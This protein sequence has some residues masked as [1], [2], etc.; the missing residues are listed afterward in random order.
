MKKLLLTT[1]T[2]L[3]A[4]LAANAVGDKWTV[5]WDDP[6]NVNVIA[7]D[8]GENVT[9][10]VSS[11]FNSSNGIFNTKN[12]G[13]W[14]AKAGINSISNDWV[15]IDLGASQ[16]LKVVEIH[17]EA[18]KATQFELYLSDSMPSYEEKG[19]YNEIT[20]AWLQSHKPDAKH[21]A[22]ADGEYITTTLL[23]ATGRYLLLYCTEYNGF[24]R[25]YGINIYQIQ[26]GDVEVENDIQSIQILPVNTYR[27]VENEVI[28]YGINQFNQP[29]E[30]FDEAENISLTCSDPSVDI[31]PE[32]SLGHFKV[33]A[34]NYGRFELLATATFTESNELTSSST[35]YS[36]INWD[37]N[38]NVAKGCT[39]FG[40]INE[41]LDQFPNNHP[42]SNAV[43]GDD[44]SYYVYNGNYGGSDSWVFIDLGNDYV[45]EA[46]EILMGEN[47]NG[48]YKVSY[49]IEGAKIPLSDLNEDW[50]DD[51]KFEGWVSSNVIQR[52]KNENNIFAF[53]R[54]VTMRYI[55]IRDIQCEGQPRYNEI[56]VAG[57]EN[58]GS[59]P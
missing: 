16:P 28:V 46:F 34:E 40:R 29:F 19:D 23:D 4:T 14:Q 56:K 1:L 22:P 8:A 31:T 57:I 26:A 41:D 36:G 51:K 24:G 25:Q 7:G 3:G 6:A 9:A 21:S 17:W 49:A 43:D 59:I 35:F 30:T 5:N 37:E 50:K 44:S 55:A 48:T 33:K 58:T 2:L 47:S 13:H 20:A 15:I 11:N 10:I 42:V 39:A 52:Y 32:S 54:P 38:E 45:V 53:E 12:E 18:A 27:N